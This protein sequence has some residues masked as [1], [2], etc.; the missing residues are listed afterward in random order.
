MML[1]RAR[2]F[3]HPCRGGATFTMV[4]F[5]M[6]LI[7]SAL[8]YYYFHRTKVLEQE[9]RTWKS[10]AG[11][12]DE[13]LAD[14]QPA[15]PASTPKPTRESFR[16]MAARLAGT[17]ATQPI[18]AEQDSAASPSEDESEVE[19]K[20]TPVPAPIRTPGPRTIAEDKSPPLLNPR[21]LDLGDSRDLQEKTRSDVAPSAETESVSQRTTPTSRSRTES[22]P[23]EGKETEVTRSSSRSTPATRQRPIRSMYDV[24]EESAAQAEPT[25]RVRAPRRSPRTQ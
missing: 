15:G 7:S 12:P 21:T 2:P 19:S 22:R 18:E 24:T 6:L 5:I 25:V 9:L 11:E 16:D 20:G 17:P 14:I 13:S 10:G 1:K 8:M 4:I 23:E 3:L